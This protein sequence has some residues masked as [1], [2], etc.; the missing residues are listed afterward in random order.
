MEEVAVSESNHG[1]ARLPTF[2]HRKIQSEVRVPGGR[3][4]REEQLC[5]RRIEG[6]QHSPSKEPSFLGEARKKRRIEELEEELRLLKEEGKEKDDQH[7]RRRS[8][9]HSGSCRSPKHAPSHKERNRKSKHR[10][11]R[12][13]SPKKRKLDHPKTPPHQH[14]HNLIWRKLQQI[15]SSPFSAEIERAKFPAR[16]VSPNLAV[17]DGKGD[18]VGHL[19]RYRQSMAIHTSNDAL[20][21]R[22]F[23]SSLGE[24]GLRWF[25]RLDHGSIRSWQE[26]SESFT[27]RFITNTRKPK[28]IDTLLALKMKAEETLK[29]YSAQYWE[30]YNDIDACD[31]DIVVKTFRFGLHQDLKLRRSLTK[32]PPIGMTD[33]MTRLEEHIRVEDDSKCSARTVEA[34]PPAD[35]KAAQP[36]QGQAKRPRRST[37][38]PRAGTCMAV[39]TTFKQPIYRLLPFIKDKPYFEWPAKMPGDPATREGKPYCS[40]HRER[41]HLTEQCRAYKYHLEQLEHVWQCTQHSN[42][43]STGF[44]PS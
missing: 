34:V 17:Y 12:S 15:S 22:I 20:M 2:N 23:P 13:M 7:Q 31:E 3:R 44:F 8:R 29:S 26:M 11:Q 18:P 30:V 24:V 10:H 4:G 32:R 1:G 40:Y 38:Q 27:A 19:S 33:L 39:H 14:Q 16:F 37:D 35:K 25:D 9:S 6:R 43:Q 36:E 5:Y 28:E 42:S 41:R 21:C